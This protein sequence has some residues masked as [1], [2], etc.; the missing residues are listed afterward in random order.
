MAWAAAKAGKGGAAGYVVIKWVVLPAHALFEIME[1]TDVRP[2]ATTFEYDELDELTSSSAGQAR[3]G[4]EP[5]LIDN[6][7]QLSVWVKT[8]AL[9]FSQLSLPGAAAGDLRQ[10]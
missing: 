1:D 8:L 5:A 10:L 4:L 3:D 6:S 2:R 7:A 9:R